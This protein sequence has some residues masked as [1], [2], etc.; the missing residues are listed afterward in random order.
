MNDAFPTFEVGKGRIGGD[1]TSSGSTFSPMQPAGLPRDAAS[2]AI[3]KAEEGKRL[4]DALLPHLKEPRAR[5]EAARAQVTKLQNYLAE[6]IAG[7]TS[8]AN[9]LGMSRSSMNGDVAM[10]QSTLH[11]W[12]ESVAQLQEKLRA[13]TAELEAAQAAYTKAA[14][15]R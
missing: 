8:A 2:E 6:A 14:M 11:A 12:E 1:V 4:I 15:P 10:C 9:R 5:L 7:R 3:A 13:A